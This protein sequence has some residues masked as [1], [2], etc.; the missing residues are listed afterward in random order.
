MPTLDP[1]LDLFARLDRWRDL[2]AYRLENRVDV[3]FAIYLRDFLQ[4]KLGV[5]LKASVIPELPL[6]TS[7]V[8]QRPDDGTSVKVDFV[9]FSADL[10]VVYF[11]ELKTDAGSF[12]AEQWRRYLAAQC[13]GFHVIVG[14]VLELSKSTSEHHKYHHLL[15]ALAE[16]GVLEMTCAAEIEDLLAKDNPRGLTR[17]LNSIKNNAA[18]PTRIELVYLQPSAVPPELRHEEAAGKVR[19]F[20][21]RDFAGFVEE[22]HKDAFSVALARHLHRWSTS[23]AGELRRCP[24]TGCGQSTLPCWEPH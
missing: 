2:P 21:L 23:P 12:D 19:L 11:V 24:R 16:A 13:A 14:G 6:K 3:F 9:L 4:A 1:I 8:D 5:A 20:N 17:L 10:S 7:I 22:N 18:D 15:C